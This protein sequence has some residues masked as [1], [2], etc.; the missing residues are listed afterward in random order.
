[1]DAR[2]VGKNKCRKSKDM[3]VKR[4]DLK[5]DKENVVRIWVRERGQ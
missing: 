5:A 2:E 1:M 3:R 4:I